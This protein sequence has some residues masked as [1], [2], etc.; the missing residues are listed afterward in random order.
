MF[1]A[2]RD[3]AQR[4]KPEKAPREM[5]KADLL[6]MGCTAAAFEGLGDTPKDVLCDPQYLTT[7]APCLAVIPDNV[8]GTGACRGRA[9]EGW[10]WGVR[11]AG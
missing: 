1:Q 4:C 9:E 2:M 5:T 7:L 10:G 11:R 8:S 6:A 3:L